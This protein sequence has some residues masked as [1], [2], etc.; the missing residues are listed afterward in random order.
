MNGVKG[1]EP[2]QSQI[3][4][5]PPCPS[6]L[7]PSSGGVNPLRIVFSVTVRGHMNCCKYSGPPA[8]VPTP[9]NLNPPNGCR[10]TSA[11]VIFRLIYKF[12]TRNSRRTRSIVEVDRENSPP[13]SAYFTPLTIANASSKFFA[14]I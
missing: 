7:L 4:P 5:A 1:S 8:F 3:P 2:Y 10:S 12:P 11:P 9:D 6:P 14:R 13:V